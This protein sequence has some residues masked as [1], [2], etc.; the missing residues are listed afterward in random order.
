MQQLPQPE[1]SADEARDTADVVLSGQAYRQAAR[2][3]SLQERLFD[4]VA[5]RVSDLFNALSSAGGRGAIAW[6]V[7]GVFSAII[8]YLVWR[9]LRSASPTPLRRGTAS[10]SI[11]ILGDRSAAEWLASAEQAEA[12]GDWRLGIRCRHRVLVA[13]LVDQ[14]ALEPRPGMTA[15]EI[16][17]VVAGTHPRAAV[18][19]QSATDL[20]KDTWYGWID[21]TR[22]DRDQFVALADQV[23]ASV[24]SAE[25]AAAGTPSE[26]A[27]SEAA[28]A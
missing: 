3:P 24:E 16:E 5:E 26:P 19:M 21:A 18:A 7:I 22:T 1:F 17:R 28:L 10:A 20:F 6:V 23:L 13:T 9:M 4:W 8:V 27:P 11:E 25:P 2:G 12:A 14:E 15:G